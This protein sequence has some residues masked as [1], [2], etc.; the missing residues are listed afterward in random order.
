MNGVSQGAFLV[1]LVLSNFV[2]SGINSDGI[3]SKFLSNHLKVIINREESVGFKKLIN[4]LPRNPDVLH[5][6]M[7][8][9]LCFV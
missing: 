5:I 9:W 3:L 2:K 4:V 1:Q 7:K 8:R 6:Q